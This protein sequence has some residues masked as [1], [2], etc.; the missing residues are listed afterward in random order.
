MR[1]TEELMR[2][3]EQMRRNAARVRAENHQLEEDIKMLEG[4]LQKLQNK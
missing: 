4:V 2:E 3:N 1:R